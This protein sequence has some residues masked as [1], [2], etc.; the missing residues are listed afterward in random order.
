MKKVLGLA[1]LV[2]ISTTAQAEMAM[3][4]IYGKL[5]KNYMYV[6]QEDFANRKSMTGVIDTDNSES[7]LGAKGSYEINSSLTANYALELGL[8]SSAADS[9]AS[10]S[11]RLRIRLAKID[12]VSNY[13]TLTM[14]Q[15]YTADALAVLK[16]DTFTGTV[17]SGVGIDYATF[18]EGQDSGIGFM[19][20]SRKDVI[21]YATPVFSG[22][23]YT[24]SVD[25][26][27]NRSNTATSAGGQPTYT[28]HLLSFDKK[29]DAMSLRLQTSY[30]HWAMSSNSD[31]SNLHFG[32]VLGFGDLTFKAGWSKQE[33]KPFTG[34]STETTRMTAGLTYAMAAHTAKVAYYKLEE[35]VGAAT[36]ESSQISAGYDYAFN[37]NVSMNTI[38]SLLDNKDST[39][40]ATNNDA[41]VL[42]VG[43]VVKF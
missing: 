8:N 21:K 31:N 12:L 32:T 35:E 4:T 11:G 6:N 17:A 27:D 29:M 23:Q 34:A 20:R 41:T 10:S 2:A 25:K 16:V 38:V 43:A 7:R 14:G 28:T 42:S 30:T 40:T 15:D 1:A 36:E 39:S 13:G 22:V 26:N 3:P 5:T 37:K 18:V 9:G 33:V 24:V 19:Y